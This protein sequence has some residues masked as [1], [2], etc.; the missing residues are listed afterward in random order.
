MNEH[1]FPHCLVWYSL[2][3]WD[4]NMKLNRACCSSARNNMPYLVSW[5]LSHCWG[6]WPSTLTTLSCSQVSTLVDE[7]YGCQIFIHLMAD[8]ISI[9][10]YFQ[11]KCV[12]GNAGCSSFVPQVVQCYNRGTDGFDVQVR[13]TSSVLLTV[14]VPSLDNKICYTCIYVVRI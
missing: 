1:P 2:R 13:L 9:A 11:L 8:F 3:K 6:Y 4:K 5:I 12:G 10:V 7:I 14:N